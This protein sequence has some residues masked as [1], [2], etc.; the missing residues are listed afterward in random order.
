MSAL[1]QSATVTCQPAIRR[2]GNPAEHS[3]L[4]ILDAN[5]HPACVKSQMAK[6]D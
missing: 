1:N 2:D 4:D 3:D 5:S 6:H